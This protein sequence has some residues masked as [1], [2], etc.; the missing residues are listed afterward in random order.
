MCAAV[1]SPIC[2]YSEAIVAHVLDVQ[3]W[4]DIFDCVYFGGRIAFKESLMNPF[5]V[6][7]C[8]HEGLNYYTLYVHYT[9]SGHIGKVVVSHAEV[10]RSIPG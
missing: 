4:V 1:Q 7:V 3:N 6:H 9:L 8:K 5:I 2:P 10:A